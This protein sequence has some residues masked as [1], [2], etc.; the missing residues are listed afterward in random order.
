MVVYAYRKS[1]GK[2]TDI[3]PMLIPFGAELSAR[4][5]YCRKDGVESGRAEDQHLRPR[6]GLFQVVYSLL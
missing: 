4:G 2:F 5:L 1:R 3:Y 6:L